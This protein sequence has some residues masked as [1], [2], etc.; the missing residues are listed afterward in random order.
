MSM[1]VCMYDAMHVCAWDMTY[2]IT[3]QVKRMSMY[4]HVCHNVTG[5]GSIINDPPPPPPPTTIT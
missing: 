1:Y 4:V 5:K 2:S 3:Y